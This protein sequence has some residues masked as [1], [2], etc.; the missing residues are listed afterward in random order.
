M[1]TLRPDRIVVGTMRGGPVGTM[2]QVYLPL[3]HAGIPLVQVIVDACQGISVTAWREAGW[4]V[5]SLT[6][7]RARQWQ[8]DAAVV[9]G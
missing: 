8:H 1:D 6:G 9:A 2:R 7:L 3:T 4:Q 5:S